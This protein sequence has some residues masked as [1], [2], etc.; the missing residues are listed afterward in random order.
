MKSLIEA[1]FRIFHAR[2][3]PFYLKKMFTLQKIYLVNKKIQVN[4]ST[5]FQMAEI[6]LTATQ[7]DSSEIQI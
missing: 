1:N 3:N 7:I 2:L 6:F 5:E 4:S